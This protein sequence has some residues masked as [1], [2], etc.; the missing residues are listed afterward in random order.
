MIGL[1]IQHVVPSQIVWQIFRGDPIEVANPSLQAAVAGIGILDVPAGV[2]DLFALMEI[3]RLVA[4]SAPLGDVAEGAPAVAAKH[5]V[6]RAVGQ[7]A[8]AGRGSA[9][10]ADDDGHLFVAQPALGSRRAVFCEG[11]GG[12][13]RPLRQHREPFKE[14]RKNVSP[15]STIPL[16]SSPVGGLLPAC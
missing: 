13:S 5:A 10:S 4:Q 9:I 8:G 7:D 1:A 16:K 3:D 2:A 6:R 15:T 11:R 14:R 12:A